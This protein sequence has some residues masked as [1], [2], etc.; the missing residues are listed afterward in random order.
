MTK[1]IV[2]KRKS[3]GK[4]VANDK[5]LNYILL[6]ADHLLSKKV[7]AGILSILLHNPKNQIKV[8]ELKKIYTVDEIKSR[9]TDQAVLRTYFG[10]DAFIVALCEWWLGN[11]K[12]PITIERMTRAIATSQ[13][14]L[15]T[16]GTINQKLIELNAII[17]KHAPKLLEIARKK[18]WW[19]AQLA[20]RKKRQKKLSP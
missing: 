18:Q 1:K 16:Q 6:K 12:S 4:H 8:R 19:E 13:E 17:K 20:N 7:P 14:E 11:Y 10:S 5:N 2:V 3:T 9:E 15:I